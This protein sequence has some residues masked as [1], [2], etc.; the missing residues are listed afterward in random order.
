MAKTAGPEP[1]AAFRTTEGET[2]RSIRKEAE[3]TKTEDDEAEE[4]FANYWA[5]KRK[6][7]TREAAMKERQEAPTGK[8][9]RLRAG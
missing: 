8:C 3:N 9:S 2:V 1:A 4:R 7:E 6:L 5:G